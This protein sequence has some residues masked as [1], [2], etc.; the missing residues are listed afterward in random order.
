MKEARLWETVKRNWGP[1]AKLM[2][3]ENTCLPGTPD[4]YVALQGRS[5][6]VE[7]KLIKGFPKRVG[8]P[9]TI[10]HFTNEQKLWLF[11]FGNAG[12]CCW[13]LVQVIDEGY[14]LFDFRQAQEMCGWTRSEWMERAHVI[15]RTHP[16]TAWVE[17]LRK[18]LMPPL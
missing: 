15:P 14:F 3:V 10:E 11:T 4:L 12:I 17:T 7:L 5:A 1:Y 16:P 6:W 9:V 2:R 18:V 8:S 13:V